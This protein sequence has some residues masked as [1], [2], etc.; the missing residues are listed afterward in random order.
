MKRHDICTF[1][2]FR[3]PAGKSPPLSE[4]VRVFTHAFEGYGTSLQSAT[5]PSSP[6]H[7]Q[8]ADLFPVACASDRAGAGLP[9]T[10]GEPRMIQLE[11]ERRCLSPPHRAQPSPAWGDTSLKV[12]SEPSSWWQY[13][14][15]RARG[16]SKFWQDFWRILMST[17]CRA[18]VLEVNVWNEWKLRDLQWEFR[19]TVYF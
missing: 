3:R 2:I 6:T 7:Y 17:A 8:G 13:E 18:M 4:D 11:H 14:A 12:V 1:H 16:E 15:L 19:Q 10:G 5:H 9:V